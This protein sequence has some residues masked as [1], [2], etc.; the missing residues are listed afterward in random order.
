MTSDEQVMAELHRRGQAR[1]FDAFF[2][3]QYGIWQW[4]AEDALAA[5]ED[6]LHAGE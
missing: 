3:H 5:R 1:C 4:D 6:E 2:L